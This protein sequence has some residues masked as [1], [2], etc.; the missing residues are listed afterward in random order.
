MKIDKSASAVRAGLIGSGIG[1]LITAV[2][3]YAARGDVSL[4][5]WILIPLLVAGLF[6]WLGDHFDRSKG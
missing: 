6:L 3:A 2:Q 4:W 5:T 1:L